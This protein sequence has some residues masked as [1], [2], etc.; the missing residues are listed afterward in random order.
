MK[1]THQR[2]PR[3]RYPVAFFLSPRGEVVPFTGDG[4]RLGALCPGGPALLDAVSG[5]RN[6]HWTATHF[7]FAVPDGWGFASILPD[8]DSGRLFPGSTWEECLST[9]GQHF[10]DRVVS[11]TSFRAV[12]AQL[13][14]DCADRLT[15]AD[16]SR[17]AIEDSASDD[18]EILTITYGSPTRR[19]ANEGYWDAPILVTLPTGEQVRVVDSNP[20]WND[21]GGRVAILDRTHCSGYHGG[22]YTVVLSAPKGAVATRPFAVEV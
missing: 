10:P 18:T 15:A 22:T 21:R 3:G 8:W 13:R 16:A 4:Y 20:N 2:Q 11:P 17:E 5:P 7:K 14:W 1:W 12:V 9:F 6:G 19:E